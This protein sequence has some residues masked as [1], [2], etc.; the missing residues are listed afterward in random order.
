MIDS[1]GTSTPEQS[2]DERLDD[3]LPV[4]MVADW[5]PR[6]G[7]HHVWFDD[8]DV[9]AVSPLVAERTVQAILKRGLR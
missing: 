2:P 3:G 6:H 7:R 5:L 1:S 9:L 8:C 4:V